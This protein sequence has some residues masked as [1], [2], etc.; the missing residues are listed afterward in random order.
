MTRDEAL[1]KVTREQAYE[2]FLGLL[3]DEWSNPHA[4]MLRHYILNSI[5]TPTVEV[6]PETEDGYMFSVQINGETFA[7]YSGS[8]WAD[9]LEPAETRAARYIAALGIEVKP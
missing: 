1:V 7:T 9:P 5:P 8:N 4:A 2:L 6:V 3:A